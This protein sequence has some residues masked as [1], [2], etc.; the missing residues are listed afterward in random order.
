MFFAPASWAT[1]ERGIEKEWLVTNGL[2]GFAAGTAI[3]AAT[4]R[5]HGLLFAALNPPVERV[6]LLAALGEEISDGQESCRLDCHE[7]WGGIYPEGYRYL[8]SF[9]L[10]PFPTFVYAWNGWLVEKTIFMVYGH[11]V[12]VIRYRVFGPEEGKLRLRLI[13]FVSCR[14]FHH[15]LRKNNWP[16]RREA[17]EAAVHLQAFTEGPWLHLYGY[18]ARWQSWPGCWFEGM[19]YREEA[20]RGLDPWEDHFLPGYFE[21]ELAA[22]EEMAIIAAAEE[23]R[24]LNPYLLQV[25]EEKRL[26]NLVEKT[27]V[28]DLFVHRLVLAADQFIVQRRSTGRRTIIAGYPWF[29]DWGRDAMIALPGLTLVTR[30]YEE[31]REILTTFADYCRDGLI[32]NSFPDDGSAPWYNTVDASLWYFYAL[33]KYLS[34]TGDREF[35]RRLYP[36]LEEIVN[37]YINGTHYHIKMQPD[38][39]ITAGAEG[40]QLTWMDAK[41]GEWVVTPRHGKPVEIAALWYNAL[42]FM[43]YLSRIFATGRGDY[44][45][46]LAFRCRESFRRQFWEE[47]HGFLCDVVGDEGKD[48]SFRPNQLIAVFLPFS[49][50]D[51][52]S[53]RQVVYQVSRRLYAVYGLRTLTRE[54]PRYRGQYT[55]D[56]ISRDGA[57][58]QGT[59]WMWFLGLYVTCYRKVHNYS[60]AS[61][62]VAERLLLPARAHLYEYGLGSMAEIFDGDFPHWPR[63]AFAQAWSVAEVLRAYVE[64]VLDRRP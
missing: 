29:S 19:Y 7:T 35:L 36:V 24:E 12:T 6:L 31:A 56:R 2:G 49:P 27:E 52:F 4:R 28:D 63:G 38:G 8:Q 16:F 33:Q 64:D 39:L 55:G 11:N 10:H 18:R 44:Y 23:W 50:L 30:R 20:A 13:P 51:R 61:R 14:H 3:G 34:Y 17:E 21:G 32:P 54:D 59:A 45:R 47:E 15:T 22:G 60:P 25:R 40:L 57:Y 58:H 1:F 53:A 37:S 48:R 26:A 9:R 46:E 42:M 41:V 62:E 43:T 5:Y